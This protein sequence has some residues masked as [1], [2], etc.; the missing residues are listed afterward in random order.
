MVLISLILALCACEAWIDVKP[1][2]R[3]SEEVLFSS[4]EGFLK[5]LNGVYVELAHPDLYGVNL[6]AGPI[7]VMGQYY[8]LSSSTHRLHYFSNYTYTDAGVKSV[9]DNTWKK[10]YAL[11]FNCNVILE[12]CGTGNPLLPTPYFELVRGE[13]LA[14]RALLHLDL[15]RLFGP[16]YTAE[17]EG[18]ACIPYM[19]LADQK[20][21]SLLLAR[22][23]RDSIVCDLKEAIALL[24]EIDP[25]LEGVRNESNPTGNNDM[26]YRQYRLNYYAVK[27][28]LARTYLWCGDK[29]NALSLAKE[30]L[31]EVQVPDEEIFPFV[32]PGDATNATIPD[33]LF[34]SEVLFAL[35]KTNRV[36]VYSALF[37]PTLDSYNLLTFAG[38]YAGGRVD[39]LYDDKNDY[40]YRIWVNHTVNTSVVLCHEKFKE[41]IP[42]AAGF[43]NGF[44][45]MMP[46]IRLSEVYLI[47]AECSASLT[48]GADYLN[49]VRNHRNCFSITPASPEALLTAV[50]LEFKK[51]T[52]GEGQLFFFYKRQGLQVI[53]NGSLATGTMNMNLN[54]YVVPLPDSEVSERID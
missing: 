17:N 54:N 42:N 34:S 39:E 22:A 8:M 41:I 29:A 50:T 25:V 11:V 18:I 24:R 1:T 43:G 14:L 5:A 32:E 21:G 2:D 53:P 26:Y 49:A 33:R 46:L 35:Y 10:A 36:D 48:E 45:Y 40:R 19:T 30:I 38:T 44:R 27:A 15:F 16:I 6:S 12:K 23:V 13:A 9:F 31:E 4:R 3:L 7:D 51:E 28:L 47:A 37:S 52:I 20:I